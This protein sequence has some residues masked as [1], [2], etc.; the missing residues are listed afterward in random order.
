MRNPY[1]IAHKYRKTTTTN[2]R[3]HIYNTRTYTT[4]LQQNFTAFKRQRGRQLAYTHLKD[5]RHT[6]EIICPQEPMKKK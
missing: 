3:A 4:Y 6:Q 5:I 1:R 2:H